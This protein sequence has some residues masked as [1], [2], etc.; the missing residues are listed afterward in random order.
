MN[1]SHLR[2][3]SFTKFYFGACYYPEHWDAATRR[4]DA[5]RM[6]D[7]GFNTVRMPEFAWDLMEPSEGRFDFALF[8]EAIATLGVAGISTILCTPTATAPRWLT[9]A[10][11]EVL[12]VNADG[13]P[14]QHGSRHHGCRGESALPQ[15]FAGDHIGDVRAFFAKR[16]RH[17]VADR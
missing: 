5:A 8:D 15:A 7:A 12:H 16:K 6:A 17:R 2:P 11:P 10:H 14:M 1:P 13:V 3:A 4:D 9:A